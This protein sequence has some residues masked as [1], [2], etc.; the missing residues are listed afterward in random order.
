M[1]KKLLA[2]VGAV[3]TF[4][5]LTASASTLG[6]LDSASVGADQTVLASCDSDGVALGYT[7]VY[8]NASNSYRTTAVTMSGI[9]AACQG[10]TYKLTLSNGTVSV[11]EAS[12]AVAVVGGNQTVALSSPVAASSI[13]KAAI[14]IAG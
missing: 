10:K 8:D 2:V 11:A 7:N 1:K 13:S 14:V 4:G 9:D 12:G 5:A 3:A 6:S